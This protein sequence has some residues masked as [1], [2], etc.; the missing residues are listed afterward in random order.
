MQLR[1]GFLKPGDK[2]KIIAPAYKSPQAQKQLNKIVQFFEKWSLTAEYSKKIFGL[3]APIS[4]LANLDHC[5]FEDLTEAIEDPKIKAIWCFRGG[6]GAIRLLPFLKHFKKIPAQKWFIGFSDITALHIYFYETWKWATV[7]GPNA[8]N[9][10]NNEVHETPLVNL[11][12]LIMGELQSF[13]ISKLIGLNK[14][15]CREHSVEAP[16]I[17]GNLSVLTRLQGTAYAL[18][19]HNRILFLEDTH[20]PARKLDAMLFQL[21]ELNTEKP[22]AVI[23]GEF[24]PIPRGEKNDVKAVLEDIADRL[25]KKDI[26]MLYA[27]GIGHTFNN[28]PLLLGADVRLR[29]GKEGSLIF[30]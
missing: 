27:K 19:I 18:S 29:L 17:G 3:S 10:V 11:K 23:V 28:F 5:R 2:I 9:L 25:E 13:K 22:K 6:Y 7:H 20:E 24:Y 26:P 16:L 1:L 4:K 15:A 12:K 21:F 14:A 30:F 8:L